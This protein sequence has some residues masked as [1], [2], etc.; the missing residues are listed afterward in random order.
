M[1][2]CN[3]NCDVVQRLLPSL[4][5]GTPVA[6]PV[7]MALIRFPPARPSVLWVSVSPAPFRSAARS[8]R[9]R[10]RRSPTP[11]PWRRADQSQ[12]TPTILSCLLPLRVSPFDSSP[13]RMYE[14]HRG[15]DEECARRRALCWRAFGSRFF[16][17][18]TASASSTWEQRAKGPREL[19]DGRTKQRHPAGGIGT[20]H[21][22]ETSNGPRDRARAKQQK[23]RQKSRLMYVSKA[24]AA[25]GKSQA[26]GQPSSLQHPYMTEPTQHFA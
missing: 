22:P 19:R 3:V 16:F 4:C 8:R 21:L 25:D 14:A 2:M 17:F 7:C 11:K 9:R 10:R 6:V 15:D 5:T 24:P 1:H 20:R 13:V 18:F 26:P 23:T 12:A